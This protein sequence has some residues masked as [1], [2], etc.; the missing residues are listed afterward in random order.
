MLDSNS[1]NIVLSCVQEATVALIITD[2]LARNEGI[3][4]LIVTYGLNTGGPHIAEWDVYTS[5]RFIQGF[6]IGSDIEMLV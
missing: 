1:E 6:Y 5:S 2:T 4:R 3:V